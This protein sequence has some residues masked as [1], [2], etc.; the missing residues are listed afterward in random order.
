MASIVHLFYNSSESVTRDAKVGVLCQVMWV[1][2]TD[3]T[4]F[5]NKYL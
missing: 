3:Q 4:S 2:D 1:A 5:A